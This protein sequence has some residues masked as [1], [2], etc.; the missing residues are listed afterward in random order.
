MTQNTIFIY[1]AFEN[2]NIIF[3]QQNIAF[4]QPIYLFVL[5]VQRHGFFL[6]NCHQR[7]E[8]TEG[9]FHLSISMFRIDTLGDFTF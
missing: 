5:A 4:E 1:F 6:L 8:S 3:L 9:L 2:E 7:F